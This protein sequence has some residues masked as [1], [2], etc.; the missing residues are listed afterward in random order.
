MTGVGETER[1]S[2]GPKGAGSDD[3]VGAEMNDVEDPVQS[4]SRA[5]APDDRSLQV[6]IVEDYQP[7]REALLAFVHREGFRAEAVADGAS[8]LAVVA[9]KRPELVILDL[10]MPV[11]DGYEFM[12]RLSRELGRGRPK[13][14][15]LTGESRLDLAQVRVGADAYVHKSGDPERLRAALRRLVR[16][17]PRATL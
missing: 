7:A 11:M 10:K 8:G 17:E 6:L 13:V 3:G 9:V 4:E 14:L 1:R 12:E 16:P 15:V 5:E 2:A